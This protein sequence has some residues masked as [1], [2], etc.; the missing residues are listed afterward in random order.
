L[1]IAPAAQGHVVGTRVSGSACDGNDEALRCFNDERTKMSPNDITT[2]YLMPRRAGACAVE[3]DF[4]DGTS[5]KTNVD[6]V[7]GEGCCGGAYAVGDDRIEVT[8]ASAQED[9]GIDGG[10]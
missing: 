9:A 6:F 3:V 5:F 8:M 7:L 1:D 10:A 2:C 4:D